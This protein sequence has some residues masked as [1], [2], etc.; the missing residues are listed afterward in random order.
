MAKTR[1][2]AAEGKQKEAKLSDDR[3]KKAAKEPKAKPVVK[4]ESEDSSSSSEDAAVQKQKVT[5]PCIR[6]SNFS[7][8]LRNGANGNEEWKEGRSR[9]FLVRLF[10]RL[11]FRL[12]FGSIR[13]LL[14]RGRE[15]RG[16]HETQESARAS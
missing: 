6:L 9:C 5:A 2:A 16:A 12:V 8:T 11:F 14:I 1:A 3:V 13:R 4:E 15:G 7:C 10:F